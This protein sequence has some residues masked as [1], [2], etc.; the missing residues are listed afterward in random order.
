LDILVIS[1]S[2]TGTLLTKRLI[3]EGNN[4]YYVNPFHRSNGITSL[5]SV[6][7]CLSSHIDF[8]IICDTGFTKENYILSQKNIPV[9]GGSEFQEKVELDKEIQITLCK[10]YKIRWLKSTTKYK[11]PLSTEIW[12][13]CGEPLYQ[14]INYIKQYRFLAGDLGVEV[15]GESIVYWSN[16][17]RNVESVH[18]IFE[19]GLF[20]FLKAIKYTGIF[21]LDAFISEDDLYPYVFNIIPRLQIPTLSCMLE[22]YNGKFGN[23]IINLLQNKQPSI[24]LRDKIAISVAVSNPP[25]PYGNYG[26]VKYVT[27][28]GNDW[29]AVRKEIAKQ[30]KEIEGPMLQYRVD[31]GLQASYLEE[32]KKYKYYKNN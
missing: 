29:I 18:R 32:L 8:A 20:D 22:L 10:R 2:Y 15:D 25:Y 13:A 17:D 24:I 3:E 11:Y 12:F 28:S 4:V 14:Y 30:I 7:R 1:S 23:L 26:L 19:N 16:L 21:S 5:P 27:S 6:Y 31:G 9:F